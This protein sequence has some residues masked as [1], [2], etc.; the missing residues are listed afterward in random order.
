[1]FRFEQ[2]HSST[3]F[4]S[5]WHI[6]FSSLPEFQINELQDDFLDCFGGFTYYFH[7]IAVFPQS[8]IQNANTHALCTSPRP[9]TSTAVIKLNID[10]SEVLHRVSLEIKSDFHFLQPGSLWNTV[11]LRVRQ[12][13]PHY[14]RCGATE[15]RVRDSEAMD[16]SHNQTVDHWLF[17][18]VFYWHSFDKMIEWKE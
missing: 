17:G 13:S 5:Q 9:S 8:W 1:M 15:N 11:F 2:K 18:F 6:N 10:F 14:P 3:F 7:I 4:P 16:H 12:D